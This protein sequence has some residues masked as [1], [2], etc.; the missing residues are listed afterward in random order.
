MSAACVITMASSTQALSPPSFFLACLLLLLLVSPSQ[1]LGAAVEVEGQIGIEVLAI[2]STDERGAPLRYPS[3]VTYDPDMDEIYVVGGGEGKVIVYGSNF[4]PT[5]SLGKGRGADSPRGIYVDHKTSTVY[6]CQARS[7]GKEPRITLFNA[8]FFPQKEI[9]FEDIPEAENFSPQNIY[10]GHNGNLYVT[11]LNTRGLLVLDPEGNFSHW[12]KPLDKIFFE[13]SKESE[14]EQQSS[15]L[16]DEPAPD[17]E[18]DEGSPDFNMRDLLPAGLLPSI[19][20]DSSSFEDKEL[21]PVQVADIKTDSRGRLYI[22]SEETSKIYVYSPKEE[23][24]FS[25]GQKG[26]STGKMSRP[27][28]LVID[29]KKKSIYVVDYMRH[30]VLIF[31]LDGRYMYEFGGMGAGPGWFQ[32]PISLALNKKGDLIVADLFNQRVQVLNVKF[33]YKYP[34]TTKD[35]D[36]KESMESSPAPDTKKETL[37][38]PDQEDDS[39]YLPEPI[40][41]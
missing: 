6:L 25:F 24:L 11:G 35:P 23:F 10:K 26:G 33:E 1:C 7:K 30:T 21:E 12:L 31:D 5:V 40:Y 16:A 4:F 3:S 18:A 29:E 9:L 8:A 20:S 39:L 15:D 27:K 2:L 17:D 36:P 28:S 22:L 41:L 34:T 13:T 38:G 14:T 19:T 37:P 32:Y